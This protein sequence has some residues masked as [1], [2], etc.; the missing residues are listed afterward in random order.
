MS[1][2]RQSFESL[3][4]LA[5]QNDISQS[6]ARVTGSLPVSWIFAVLSIEGMP[7]RKERND[8]Y[9]RYSF[10]VAEMKSISPQL[11]AEFEVKVREE[12][13]REETEV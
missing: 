6:V 8:L 2:E 5:T 9:A 1:S 12:R 10:D 4:S 7:V 3:P 11:E 13:R